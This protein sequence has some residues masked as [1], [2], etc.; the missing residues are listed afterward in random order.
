[1]RRPQKFPGIILVAVIGVMLYLSTFGW[2]VTKAVVSV[3]SNENNLRAANLRRHVYTLS[4]QI[5]WRSVEDY[6]NLKKAAEYL[7]DELSS[8]G[9]EV[10]RQGFW[11]KGRIVNN[12]IAQ[13]KGTQYPDKIILVGANYDS[14]FNPGADAN[15]SGVAALIELADIFS[16]KENKATLRLVG[17]TNMEPP[18]FGSPQMGSVVYVEKAREQK[19][20]IVA[21]II[22]HSIG[23]YSNERNSQR[24]PPLLGPFYPDKGNFMMIV[25]NFSSFTLWNFAGS[26]FRKNTSLSSHSVL[27][28]DFLDSDRW[29]FWK[30]RYPTIL[31]TDTGFYRNPYFHSVEDNY[32]KLNYHNMAQV[33]EG[34]GAV[35]GEL[36]GQ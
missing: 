12:I 24:Y 2:H 23:Y 26:S 29:A 18:F 1:M 13:K 35:I 22:L 33:V 11:V 36:T 30:G 17:F 14:Y 6:D 21:A 15:A 4:N 32:Q 9:F 7:E 19:E 34:V 28:F 20:N 27:A 5:G 16:K 25:G 8:R 10:E 31:L 3:Y